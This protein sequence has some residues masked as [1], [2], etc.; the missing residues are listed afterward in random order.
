MFGAELS[1]AENDN[2]WMIPGPPVDVGDSADCFRKASVSH[3]RASP[4]GVKIV[5]SKRGLDF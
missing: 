3:C 2:L 1:A 4:L 5:S